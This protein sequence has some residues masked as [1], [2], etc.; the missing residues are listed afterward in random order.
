MER[1]LFTVPFKKLFFI[2]CPI[3]MPF[4]WLRGSNWNM[5]RIGRLGALVGARELYTQKLAHMHVRTHSH[6]SVE[7][8][9]T[10][11]SFLQYRLQFHSGGACEIYS[12]RVLISYSVSRF[13]GPHSA[14]VAMR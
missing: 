12:T 2:G 5:P 10:Q 13:S 11:I 1:M 4:D 3:F 9:E 6:T 8:T 14:I 7:R